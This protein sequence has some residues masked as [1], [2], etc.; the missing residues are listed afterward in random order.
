MSHVSSFGPTMSLAVAGKAI[1]P[2]ASP[3]GRRPLVSEPV[4][5]AGAVG[6][7]VTNAFG[8]GL[9]GMRVE[10]VDDDKS[11]VGSTI[12][13][14]GGRFVVDD[15]APGTYKLR[16][17]DD[18]DGD[19]EKAWFGGRT[20]RTAES[21]AVMPQQ[22]V[23]DVDVVLRSTARIDVDVSATKRKTDVVVVVT[24]RATGAPATGAVEFSN[25]DVQVTVPLV[26][27]RAPFSFADRAGGKG[28]KKMLRV[29]Y[30]GD[31]ETRPA[32]TKVRLRQ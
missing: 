11:V 14:V 1:G 28:S 29:D 27:G 31:R 6:G 5:V 19:F 13:G 18:T 22:A 4:V 8:R 17:L 24:H 10:I 16:A 7:S 9:R 23:E 2:A 3:T 25:K 20:F 21:F 15:V 12:T 26:D 30:V 32:S